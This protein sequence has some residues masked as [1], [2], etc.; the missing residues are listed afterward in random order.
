MVTPS[1]YTAYAPYLWHHAPI[2][3]EHH[4]QEHD[5]TIP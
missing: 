2:I 1:F 5:T 3:T 4:I